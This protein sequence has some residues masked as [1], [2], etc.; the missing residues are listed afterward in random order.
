M[1]GDGTFFSK[2]YFV[3]EQVDDVAKKTQK[4]LGAKPVEKRAPATQALKGKQTQ[5]GL[6]SFFKQK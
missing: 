2:D 6:A 5:A 4:S 1:T 3:W